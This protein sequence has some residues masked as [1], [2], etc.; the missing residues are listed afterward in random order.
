MTDCFYEQAAVRREKG[1]REAL[2]YLMLVAAV[3]LAVGAVWAAGRAFTEVAILPWAPAALGMLAVAAALFLFR[4]R[5]RA[6]YEYTFTNGELDLAVVYNNEK[7]RQLETVRLGECEAFGQVRGAAFGRIANDP[8]VTQLRRFVN[9]DAELYY[10]LCRQAG[11]RCVVV[12]EPDTELLGC[13]RRWLPRGIEQ[14]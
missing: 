9:R 14:E 7:R 4:G 11:Q 6:E 13:I 12:V 5:L 3:V 10:F 8:S 1:P 2:Y